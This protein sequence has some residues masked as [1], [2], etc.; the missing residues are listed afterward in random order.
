MDWSQ[1]ILVAAPNG[2][3]WYCAKSNIRV[4]FTFQT[5]TLYLLY[6]VYCILP[7][8]LQW[9]VTVKKRAEASF[10]PFQTLECILQY[11]YQS[12]LELQNVSDF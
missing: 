7:T 11:H 2:S 1:G 8:T 10:R 9:K 5:E 4:V 3:W 12:V 6:T